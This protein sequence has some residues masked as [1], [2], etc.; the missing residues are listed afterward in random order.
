[1]DTAPQRTL[2]VA[3]F[4]FEHYASVRASDHVD[5]PA[6]VHVETSGIAL[7]AP[8]KAKSKGSRSG[9][10]D[11]GINSSSQSEAPALSFPTPKKAPKTMSKQQMRQAKKLASQS[12]TAAAAADQSEDAPT[13][14]E[15]M[16]M[17]SAQMTDIVRA[18]RLL[19]ENGGD[20]NLALDAH[21]AEEEEEEKEM[22][23]IIAS[24]ETL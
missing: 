10:S 9:N 23:E 19:E 18:R 24:I 1:M 22:K 20:L 21:M 4:G 6:N 14:N 5:G 17:E 2:H 11:S 12:A 13:F 3:Y 8:A 16:L 15:R 7:S